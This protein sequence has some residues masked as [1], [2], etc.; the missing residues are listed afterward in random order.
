MTAWGY[1]DPVVG[2]GLRRHLLAIPN[3]TDN[4]GCVELAIAEGDDYLIARLGHEKGAS[5]FSGHRA[6]NWRPSTLEL[7]LDGRVLDLDATLLGVDFLDEGVDDAVALTHGSVPP[8]A[9]LH[10]ARKSASCS[11]MS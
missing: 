3:K 9:A 10:G 2:G 4:I 5:L 7:V 11:R 1:D 8:L 6:R